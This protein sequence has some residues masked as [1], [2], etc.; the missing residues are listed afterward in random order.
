MKPPPV[1][2]VPAR[3]RD[4]KWFNL[5]GNICER[6][7]KRARLKFRPI[8]KVNDPKIGPPAD[9]C[10]SICPGM[11]D[12]AVVLSSWIPRLGEHCPSDRAINFKWSGFLRGYKADAVVFAQLPSRCKIG[13]AAREIGVNREHSLPVEP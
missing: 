10:Q 2:S 7:D 13:R 9:D 1:T 3:V 8:Y 11:Y 6:R 12:F 5:S 4:T